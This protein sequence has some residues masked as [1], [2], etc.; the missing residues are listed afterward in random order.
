MKWEEIW[1]A[2]G[3]FCTV[4][5]QVHQTS[6][7][8]PLSCRLYTKCFPFLQHNVSLVIETLIKWIRP[9]VPGLNSRQT[10]Q[11]SE[12]HCAGFHGELTGE[13]HISS[14]QSNRK[15]RVSSATPNQD[16]SCSEM[17]LGIV[18][19]SL[20]PSRFFSCSLVPGGGGWVV[21]GWM[22]GSGELAFMMAPSPGA[23]TDGQESLAPFSSPV[24]A[25][26]F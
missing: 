3:V 6:F 13:K 18:P 24:P 22:G 19:I 1:S 11:S 25:C 4:N 23:S 20:F 21:G 5:L 14:Y 9:I 26:R 10:W 12:M 8:L 7:S 2:L 17:C 16:R 15:W